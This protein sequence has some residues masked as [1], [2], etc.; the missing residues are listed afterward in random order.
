MVSNVHAFKST[1]M[2][3]KGE[4]ALKGLTVTA[5]MGYG[6][7][8]LLA[9]WPEVKASGMVVFPDHLLLCNPFVGESYLEAGVNDEMSNFQSA[10]ADQEVVPGVVNQP[11]QQA[12]VQAETIAVQDKVGNEPI[13][14]TTAT[15]ENSN[16]N[17]R[18]KNNFATDQKT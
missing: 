18:S 15:L 7:E 11:Q 1:L 2:D 9:K 3:G 6:R 5:D 16:S 10:D 13:T 12:Q 14:A 4:R 8:R 17:R